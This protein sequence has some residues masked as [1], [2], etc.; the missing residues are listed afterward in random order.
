MDIV[1]NIVNDLSSISDGEI[2]SWSQINETLKH[3]IEN[4]ILSPNK[5]HCLCLPQNPQNLSQIVAYAHKNQ[6]SIIILGKGSK[7]NWGNLR[8]KCDLVIST[9]KLN[10][11]VDHSVGDFTITVGGGIT[12]TS[13]QNHLKGFNQYLPVDPLFP[14]IATMGGIIATAD[15]GSLRHKYN[16]IRD[17]IL[18]ISFVRN[19]GEIVKAGGKV[20][21]NVAGYDLMKLLT[22]S[23]GSLGIITEVTLR[24]YPLL[25]HTQTVFISGDSN[26]IDQGIKLLRNSLLTPVKADLLSA[27]L[28]KDLALGDNMGLLVQFQGILESIHSQ[29]LQLENMA[30]NLGLRVDFYQENQGDNIYEKINYLLTSSNIDNFNNSVTC[31][32]GILPT[33]GVKILEKLQV[34]SLEKERAIIH[35]GAGIGR[36]YLQQEKLL[37]ALKIMRS[38]CQEYQGYLILLDAPIRVKKEFETFGYNGNAMTIMEKIKQQFDP[39]NMF[40]PGIFLS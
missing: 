6:L 19:D 9:E 29:G 10:S 35:L 32:L 12:L 26:K 7:L 38:H 15:G 5:P 8:E 34:L 33:F 36:I 14:E 3:K 1:T 22:G 31:K 16:G 37:G 24:L 40:N 39:K 18:G 20:V 21:K 23:Y 25:N 17:L 2:I 4:S 13:L 30:K 11:I 27:S 28:V